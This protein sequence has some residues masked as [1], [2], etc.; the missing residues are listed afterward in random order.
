MRPFKRKG[1]KK[2]TIKVRYPDGTWKQ[3]QAYTDRRASEK[4][5][6]DLQAQIDRGD[7]GLVDQFRD[8]SATPLTTHLEAFVQSLRASECTEGY[9]SDTRSRLTRAFEAMGATLPRHLAV[10]AAEQYVVWLKV[11]GRSAKTRSHVIAAL[12][13][14]STWGYRAKRLRTDLL[15]GLKRIKRKVCEADAVHNR[16]YV[17]VDEVK[18][19]IASCQTRVHDAYVRTHPAAPDAIRREL[20]WK[21]GRRA[22]A[23]LLAY[24]AGLRRGEASHALWGDVDLDRA[25]GQITIRAANAKSDRTRVLPLPGEVVEH[26]QSWMV[27]T[28]NYLGRPVDSTDPICPLS[29]GFVDRYRADVE[30]AGVLWET[31]HGFG[32]FH[33][34]RCSYLTNLYR[35][36][37][38]PLTMQSLAGHANIAQTMRY[39]KG[40]V[41]TRE[42]VDALPSLS[43]TTC[44]TTDR[45]QGENSR[46]TQRHAADSVE[47]VGSGGSPHNSREDL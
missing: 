46:D 43:C 16:R 36:G 27:A 12:K 38:H 23:V 44:D 1:A 26:L 25:N 35:A 28:Q 6:A 22:V 18:R 3:V 24:C 19:I 13:Q 15:E 39:C 20:R 31:A 8:H 14:F 40:G 17:S 47:H 29:R 11:K 2:Y 37:V 30:A 7:V 21:G 45:G 34:L 5:Q 33:A 42:A 32:D 41:A 10:E 9:V 4:R